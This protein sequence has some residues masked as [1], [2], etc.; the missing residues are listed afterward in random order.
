LADNVKARW[1][2]NELNNEY[3]R[4]HAKKK[5]RSQIEIYNYLYQKNLRSAETTFQSLKEIK[6]EPEGVLMSEVVTVT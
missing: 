2:N 1:L 6:K 4:D 3:K 5:V